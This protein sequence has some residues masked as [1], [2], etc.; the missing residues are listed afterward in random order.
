[1]H[2]SYMHISYILVTYILVGRVD[3]YVIDMCFQEVRKQF[4]PLVFAL[5]I[6]VKQT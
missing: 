4:I 6:L 3:M 1:M 5:N 2:F